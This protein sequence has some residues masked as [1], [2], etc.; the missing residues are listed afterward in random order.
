MGGRGSYQVVRIIRF[1]VEFWDRT[2]L[3]EQQTIFGRDKNS[4]APLGM[5]HEHDEPTTP[6]ILK[7]RL[8]RWM[9]IFG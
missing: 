5:Q 6:K 1:K 2:P 3:Q 7:G 4:G 8:S 9:P